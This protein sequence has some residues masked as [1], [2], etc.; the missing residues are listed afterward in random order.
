ML[1]RNHSQREDVEIVALLKDCTK[2]KDVFRGISIHA[3]VVKN[4]LLAK[5]PYV[6]SMLISMYAKCGMVSKAQ[7][8]LEEIPIRDV[9]T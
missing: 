9:V 4:G 1:I 6:A 8:V 5:S 7:Q 3:D 2:R